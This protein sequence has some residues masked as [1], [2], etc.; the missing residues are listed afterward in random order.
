MEDERKKKIEGGI[1]D[2]SED[3]YD[4]KTL[5]AIDEP[6]RELLDKYSSACGDRSHPVIGILKEMGY[7]ETWK[8]D[9]PQRNKSKKEF[10]CRIDGIKFDLSPES[11]VSI[12]TYIEEISERKSAYGAAILHPLVVAYVCQGLPEETR[13]KLCLDKS[14]YFEMRHGL[15]GSPE[16]RH[17]DTVKERIG[18][19][20]GIDGDDLEAVIDDDAF[21]ER[22][23]LKIREPLDAAADHIGLYVYPD[24]ENVGV[25]FA[26]WIRKTEGETE[27]E[28]RDLVR[29]IIREYSEPYRTKMDQLITTEDQTRL[30]RVSIALRCTLDSFGE[31]CR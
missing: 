1:R 3:L 26:A 16:L 20:L 25:S 4:L 29:P 13:K 21:W 8:K 15:K 22:K 28:I 24:E 10:A 5:K 23:D 7:H 19:E 6:T 14:I 30:E 2:L 11:M 18:D 9:Y 17:Y 31:Y 27:E 12:I